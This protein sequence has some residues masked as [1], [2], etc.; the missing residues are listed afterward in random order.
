MRVLISLTRCRLP[1]PPW[2]GLSLNR[3]LERHSPSGAAASIPNT[4]CRTAHPLRFVRKSKIV[5]GFLA[6]PVGLCLTRCITSSRGCL[7]KTWWHYFALYP[8]IASEDK[9][10]SIWNRKHRPGRII[11][12]RRVLPELVIKPIPL[13][14]VPLY[15]WYRSLC[16]AQFAPG[17][18]KTGRYSDLCQPRRFLSARPSRPDHPLRS[19]PAACAAYLPGPGAR[20]QRPVR[21]APGGRVGRRQRHA[22]GG[23]RL[24]KICRYWLPVVLLGC[25]PG[26]KTG[27]PV[28]AL[29]P[30]ASI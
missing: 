10:G 15:R 19:N 20:I 14:Q 26:A 1:L 17:R 9:N 30:A 4:P 7:S 3:P 27:Y 23:T 2:T 6:K 16:R 25:N 18:A 22:G 24:G 13:R 29:W 12:L 8:T 21:K 11:R 5:C 28:R